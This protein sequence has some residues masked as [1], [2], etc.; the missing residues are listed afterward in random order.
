MKKIT[1]IFI[2]FASINTS[3]AQLPTFQ[4][5][6]LAGGN[7]Y[8]S[9]KF[10]AVKPTAD[11]GFI[12][13]GNAQGSFSAG[14][15]SYIKGYHYNIFAA[16]D[17]WVVKFSSTGQI[18]W[19]RCFGGSYNDDALGVCLSGDGGYIV[20]GYAQSTDGDLAGVS[21]QNNTVWVFKIDGSGNL[22]WSKN[23]FSVN[24]GDESSEAGNDIIA[25]KD[26]GYMVSGSAYNA[27][28]AKGSV[29]ALLWK[30]DEYGNT[31]WT[32]VFGGTGIDYGSHVIQL[33]DK[34]YIL[35]ASAASGN[36][37]LTGDNNNSTD[38][39]FWLVRTDSSGNLLWQKVPDPTLQSQE[40]IHDFIRCDDGSYAIVGTDQADVGGTIYFQA[41][42]L[43]HTD[44]SGNLL[45]EKNYGNY[46]STGGS[47]G[48]GWGIVQSADGNFIIDGQTVQ[49]DTSFHNQCYGGFIM[50]IEQGAGSLIGY[51]G[52]PDVPYNINPQHDNNGFLFG[53]A[54]SASG[55]I[56]VCGEYGDGTS[57]FLDSIITA[58]NWDGSG[59]SG[60]VT[61]LNDMSGTL[62]VTLLSFTARLVN[63]Q[64]LLQWSTAQEINSSYFSVMRSS[65]GVNFSE[66]ANVP[67]QG[68]GNSINTYSATDPSPLKGA[69]Y[70]RL[71]EV[72]IDGK[73]TN[74]P[75]VLVTVT[76]ANL[77]KAYPNPV[78]DVVHL[79]V[80][81]PD[82][83]Q[84]MLQLF[85]I[86]GKLSASKTAQFTAG[87]NIIEWN[88]SALTT[89]TY[90]IRISNADTPVIKI[91][92]E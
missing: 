77:F 3:I 81:S 68:K 59:S 5:Q 89:G 35:T 42:F 16:I 36:G 66:I 30:L 25:T 40:T 57:V 32:K 86:S 14:D 2:F 71:K 51:Q 31:T 79:L 39:H 1:F 33:P 78:R 22:L 73:A 23:L 85:D 83:R 44:S 41:I 74:S 60:Y 50:K 64:T 54:K 15:S 75:V 19:G 63:A 6:Q 24:S 7:V 20:S 88:L 76:I 46:Q 90:F 43:M 58:H 48:V 55:T 10:N 80:T 21:T 8:S 70:Y 12:A 49:T 87:N 56:A 47:S 18:Q 65:D 67:G 82:I 17:A 37:D 92:K 26:G 34:G 11:G 27:P 13:V 9:T 28:M 84:V 53:I 69:N 61:T 72:D 45:W 91:V 62:P 4:W 52:Y 29:D 38:N